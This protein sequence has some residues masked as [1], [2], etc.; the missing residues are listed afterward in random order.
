[1]NLY[2]AT[3]PHGTWVWNELHVPDAPNALAFY[4]AERTFQVEFHRRSSCVIRDR[5]VTRDADRHGGPAR[6]APVAAAALGKYSDVAAP[7]VNGVIVATM[8]NAAI[9]KLLVQ[10]AE[11]V[12]GKS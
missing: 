4:A 5:G 11:V 6:P 10:F 2:R 1:M 7:T 9:Q 8:K 3:A 12:G